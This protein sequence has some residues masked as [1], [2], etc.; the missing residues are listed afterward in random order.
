MPKKHISDIL[1]FMNSYSIIKLQVKSKGLTLLKMKQLKLPHYQV[2]FKFQKLLRLLIQM[3]IYRKKVGQQ[4]ELKVT[5]KIN[6]ME[7]WM[8][9]MEHRMLTN[10]MRK[11]ITKCNQWMMILKV[12][13]TQSSD[14]LNFLQNKRWLFKMDLKLGIQSSKTSLTQKLKNWKIKSHQRKNDR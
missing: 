9:N 7:T 2:L 4:V 8:R 11:W 5:S 3:K 12:K 1:D 13:L 6:R 14:K 10:K